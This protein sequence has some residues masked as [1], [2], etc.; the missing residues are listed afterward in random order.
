MKNETNNRR[1]FIQALTATAS[2]SALSG[3][4]FAAN[5]KSIGRVVVIGGGFGGATAA[6]YLR[7]WSGGR[8]EVTLIERNKEFISCPASNEV[9]AGNRGLAVGHH[10][11]DGFIAGRVLCHLAG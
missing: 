7:L 3:T 11:G 4:A 9:L 8:I 2:L 10:G 1:Q 6:K 5:K